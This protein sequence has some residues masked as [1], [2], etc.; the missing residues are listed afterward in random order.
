M[1]GLLDTCG[2]SREM[3]S[4]GWDWDQPSAAIG[5]SLPVRAGGFVPTLAPRR[6]ALLI[7]AASIKCSYA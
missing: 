6:A 2:R 7:V 1:L 4:G 5:L 3:G